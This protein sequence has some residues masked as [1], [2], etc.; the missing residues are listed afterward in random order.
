MSTWSRVLAG[1]GAVALLSAAV[2]ALAPGLFPVPRSQLQPFLDAVT[3]N[4]GL[5]GLAGLAAAI[6]VVQG[7]WSST[8]PPRPPSLSAGDRDDAPATPTVGADFDERLAATGR[9]GTR[10]T[11]AE[12]TVREDLRRLAIDAHR[13]A[14]G[15]DWE[16]AARAVETGEWT[17]DPA[18][19]AF[20]GGPDAPTVPL[21][22]WFRDVLS[23]EGAF[24]R[25]TTRTI[26]AVYALASDDE[27]RP[28][29]FDR[30]RTRAGADA[31]DT[32][33]T[34]PPSPTGSTDADR[35]VTER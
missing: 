1:T 27:W 25:Q 11:E 23:D 4:V 15:C 29:R 5:A 6:A 35:G 14:T 24:H 17:D 7:L 31:A 19:A 13:E 32:D 20:V 26:R 10:T 16:R 21:R 30:V 2:L 34:T 18:A 8:T 9:V 12:A 3:E 28:E 33:D 22:V